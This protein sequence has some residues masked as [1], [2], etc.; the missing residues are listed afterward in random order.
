MRH[1]IIGASV[2]DLATLKP[3]ERSSLRKYNH[4]LPISKGKG[5]R[6]RQL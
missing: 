2:V 5:Y 1:E 6:G 3:L 4:R